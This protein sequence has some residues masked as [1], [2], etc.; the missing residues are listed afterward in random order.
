VENAVSTLGLEQARRKSAILP[1]KRRQGVF[2]LQN[3][4][5]RRPDCIL[6]AQDG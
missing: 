6:L 3:Q 1:P 5:L 4:K 2:W